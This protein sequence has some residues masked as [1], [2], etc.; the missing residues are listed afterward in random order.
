MMTQLL[1]G[2]DKEVAEWVRE[3]IGLSDFGLCTAIGV[4]KDNKLICGVV[5]NNYMKSPQGVPISIEMSIAA[6]DKA[7]CTR[8]NIHTLFV[9]PF[10]QL[11]VKRV[12]T[13][14]PADNPR[15]RAFNERFG[16][17]LEGIGREAWPLG[18]DCACYSLLKHECKW[19][20]YG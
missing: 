12:Q 9:Y 5:Y 4:L 11:N 18:G 3:Q 8:Y 2:H 17:K 7:W 15:I 1:I 6:I 10:I 19:I 16:F 14:C 13:T 20:E